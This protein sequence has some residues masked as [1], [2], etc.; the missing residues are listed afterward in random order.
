MGVNSLPICISPE[1]LL[2][3]IMTL[4]KDPNS[5]SEL[6]F[7]LNAYFTPSLSQNSLLSQNFVNQALPVLPKTLIWETIFN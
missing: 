3:C 6:E 7:L 2:A 4:R 5:K 1:R